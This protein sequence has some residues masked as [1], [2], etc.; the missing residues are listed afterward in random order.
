MVGVSNYLERNGVRNT[1]LVITHI[2]NAF[3]LRVSNAILG[4]FG[5]T[6]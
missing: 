5:E 2:W 6:V 1:V 3:D 4:S